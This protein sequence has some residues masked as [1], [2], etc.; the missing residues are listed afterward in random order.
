VSTRTVHITLPSSLNPEDVL[1]AGHDFSPR[2]MELFPAVRAEHFEV[3]EQGDTTADVTEG[4]PAGVGINWERCD[5]DWST[6]GSVIATVTDSN[7]YKPGASR[8]E[9]RATP[10]EGGSTVE[11]IWVREF[12]SNARGRIFGTAFRL[13]GNPIFS[14]EAKKILRNMERRAG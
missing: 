4:T 10:A 5:Y 13:L 11:M 8:W 9:L 14:N 6:S 12:R 2:R 7:V 1:A 3:H